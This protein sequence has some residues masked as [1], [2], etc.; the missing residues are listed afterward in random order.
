MEFG[1]TVRSLDQNNKSRT[2][3]WLGQQTLAW[4]IPIIWI[5]A[6]SN[7]PVWGDETASP[8]GWFGI[9]VLNP[10]VIFITA[11][12]IGRY[13]QTV[14]CPDNVVGKRIWIVPVVIFVLAI[15]CDYW[16]GVFTWH[17]FVKGYLV[18]FKGEKG[19]LLRE[20][21][22]YPLLSSVAYSLGS[23]TQQRVHK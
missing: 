22:T 11:Y 16:D 2:L 9:Q 7:V 15:F 20:I 19:S 21:L 5:L 6:A 1:E 10:I 17:S 4:W 18:W 13:V 14:V 23:W 3:R 8:F 12:F